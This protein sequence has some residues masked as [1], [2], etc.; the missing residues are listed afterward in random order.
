MGLRRLVLPGRRLRRVARIGDRRLPWRGAAALE[1][2][3]GLSD[4][5][6]AEY[7]AALYGPGGCY[8]R[9][10]E[11]ND[12]DVR[13]DPARVEAEKYVS[14]LWQS[15]ALDPVHAAWSECMRGEGYV[16]AT[17]RDARDSIWDDADRYTVEGEPITPREMTEK[18]DEEIAL[19]QADVGCQLLDRLRAG[20]GPDHAR[21]PAGVPR[22][23]P[24]APR[25]LN[26]Q[27]GRGSGGCMETRM[28][29]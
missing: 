11:T 19:A 3:E 10:D 5:A 12:D 14:S 4:E 16:F 28:G 1:Y 25:A 26:P 18:I 29:P 22:S 24:R 7:E 13:V 6:R 2:E 27:A 9:Y 23:A 8:D 20:D 17:P 21:A 15:G